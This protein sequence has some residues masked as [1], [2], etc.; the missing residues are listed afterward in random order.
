MVPRLGWLLPGCF[1]LW[2]PLLLAV[3]SDVGAY[4]V[5]TLYWNA[6]SPRYACLLPFTRFSEDACALLA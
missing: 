1:R 4:K 6:T 3:G 2:I 5:V